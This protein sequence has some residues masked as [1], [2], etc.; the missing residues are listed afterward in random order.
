[1][2]I[3]T[4]QQRVDKLFALALIINCHGRIDIASGARLDM[5]T[6]GERTDQSPR[7]VERIQVGADRFELG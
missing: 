4:P 6:N 7:G 3:P 5:D 1:M 2:R